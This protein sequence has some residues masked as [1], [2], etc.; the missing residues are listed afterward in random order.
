MFPSHQNTQHLQILCSVFTLIPEIECFYFLPAK[1]SILHPV[2][3]YWKFVTLLL[4]LW[5][6]KIRTC[7][8][9]VWR[10][11]S[12]TEHNFLCLFQEKIHILWYGILEI[13]LKLDFLLQFHL[14]PSLCSWL[15]C[16]LAFT[17]IVLNTRNI[18]FIPS[19][20]ASFPWLICA[21]PLR[22]PQLRSHL[23]QEPSFT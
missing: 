18:L 23:L 2:N 1:Y 16:L 6:K 13:V 4:H 11:C 12:Y 10:I 3:L 8:K 15:S 5:K 20:S 9:W 19:V 14:L 7:L 17:H 22:I 21:G